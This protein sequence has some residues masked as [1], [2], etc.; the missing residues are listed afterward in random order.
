MTQSKAAHL[1]FFEA[2]Q[3]LVIVNMRT[4]S[5]E[6]ITEIQTDEESLKKVLCRAQNKILTTMKGSVLIEDPIL[7]ESLPEEE[8]EIVEQLEELTLGEDEGLET[9]ISRRT[10]QIF[11]SADDTLTAASIEFKFPTSGTL[12][13]NYEEMNFHNVQ[14]RNRARRV[15]S[16][17]M[18]TP[19]LELASIPFDPGSYKDLNLNLNPDPRAEQPDTAPVDA[20]K[21]HKNTVNQLKGEAHQNTS[22]EE[23]DDDEEEDDYDDEYGG[24]ASSQDPQTD[25]SLHETRK[26]FEDLE[27]KLTDQQIVDIRFEEFNKLMANQVER[28]LAEKQ[29]KDV[30]ESKAT[31]TTLTSTADGSGIDHGPGGAYPTA[32]GVNPGIPE[33]RGK[34]S[35]EKISNGG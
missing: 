24:D 8:D 4:A 20:R 21:L 11:Q 25:K 1:A 14:R 7:L 30:S 12:N 22:G 15:A 17:A 23:R 28:Q 34:T 29:A 16:L 10:D 3:E 6:E 9:E 35:K 31:R 2:A 19:L 26:I 13:K 5:L 32:K 33:E 18:N 27:L